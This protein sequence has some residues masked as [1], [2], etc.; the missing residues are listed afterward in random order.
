MDLL[1]AL[2][3]HTSSH[4]RIRGKLSSSF[5]ATSGVRQGYPNFVL[6]SLRHRQGNGGCFRKS[7]GHDNETD[8]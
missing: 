8:K 2:Y 4:V 1:R 7:K 5:K 6:V 3:S